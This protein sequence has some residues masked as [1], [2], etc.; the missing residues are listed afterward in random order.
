PPSTFSVI[1][2]GDR[3]V[4]KWSQNAESNP[5]F[6]G[7]KI[8]RALQEIDSTYYLIKDF[9]V[10]DIPTDPENSSMNRFD[11]MSPI[12]GLNYYYYIVSYDDGTLDPDGRVL[13]SSLFY[14]RTTVSA[15]L[16]RP[17]G[18]VLEDIRI[19]P[20]PYNI[21]AQKMQF[22]TGA[23]KEDK[24]AFFNVPQFCKV[25][26]FTERGDLIKQISHTDGSGDIYWNLVTSDRQV[27]VSGVYIIY[28]EVIQ[29][30]TD[31][32]GNVVF[33]IGDSIYKKLIVVR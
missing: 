3:I 13:S 9:P 4:L 5:H 32:Q 8:Y 11:D 15:F 33:N 16:K 25:S 29:E 20:N 24:V 18:E 22:G 14:T 2:G 12:R 27:V 30:C 28:F 1:S 6:A 26:I 21:R 23:G 7:Y 19:V 31:N 10:G 17:A